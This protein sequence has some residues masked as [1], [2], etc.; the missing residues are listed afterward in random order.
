H[1]YIVY[2]NNTF[3]AISYTNSYQDS[4]LNEYKTY[5]YYITAVDEADNEGNASATASGIPIDIKAPG[6]PTIIEP[7]QKSGR[8]AILIIRSPSDVD[9]LYYNI[10]RS[11]VSGFILD[12]STLIA[13][14]WPK[15]GEFTTYLDEDLAIG[16]YY[17]R[18][19]ALDEKF[20]ASLPSNEALIMITLY[21]P[22]WI[23][24]TDNGNGDLTLRW[25]DNPNITL[26]S[27]F[28]VIRWYRIYRMN[29]SNHI[30]YYLGNVSS[31][32]ISGV[33]YQFI[34]YGLPNGNWTYYLTTVDKFYGESIFSPP[35]STIIYDFVPP[36]APT[37]LHSVTPNGLPNV[38]IAWTRPTNLNNGSDV[39][40]Y[41]IYISRTPI[42][43]IT[44]LLPNATIY[45]FGWHPV[46]IIRDSY[47]P[48]TSYTFYNLSDDI[49][50]I[51]VIAYDENGYSSSLPMYINYTVDTTQPTIYENT[52][53][54]PSQQPVGK[55][56]NITITLY[57]I[58]GIASVFIQFTTDEITYDIVSMSVLTDFPNGTLIFSGSIPGQVAGTIVHFTINV[59][60]S[61]DNS[62]TSTVFSYEVIGEETPWTM[63]IVA[64]AAIAAGAIAGA[65]VITRMRAKGK[66]KEY[67]AEELLPLPI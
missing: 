26:P 67:V 32:G 4:G 43:N 58:S 14:Y 66:K 57:D 22:Y 50:Y 39:F 18:V 64:I 16:P 34:D 27:E 44:G 59:I 2:R 47:Y 53:Q 3:I 37:G 52:I 33:Q 55:A 38:T 42:T 23:S 20:Q 65:M 49:Y 10:Y 19:V 56:A 63:I 7:I 24:K 15:T 9:V 12:N 45:G 13:L 60:D 28:N 35:N 17:Y 11:N 51:V 61:Y 40:R 6:P 5:I 46:G 62:R 41:E 1:H 30:L 25:K 54:A 29:S 31:L 36:G 21:A 48:L 8:T